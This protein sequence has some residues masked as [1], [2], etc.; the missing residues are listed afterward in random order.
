MLQKFI[1]MAP[2]HNKR[3]LFT[4]IFLYCR[5]VLNMESRPTTMISIHFFGNVPTDTVLREYSRLSYKLEKVKS[6]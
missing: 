6:Q 3:K 1:A 5:F 2:Y 4:K